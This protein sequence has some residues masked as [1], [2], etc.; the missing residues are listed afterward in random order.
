VQAFTRIVLPQATKIV[1]PAFGT[2]IIG[3]FHNTQ[4]AFL[5]GAVDMIGRAKTVGFTSGHSLEAYVS[6]AIIYIVC[7]LILRFVF[8]R[9]DKLFNYGRKE[10]GAIGI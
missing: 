3:M 6:T 8:Y 10:V 1:L 7:S 9:L 2:D 4:I 5:L